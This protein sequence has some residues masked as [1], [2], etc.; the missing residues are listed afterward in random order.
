MLSL[1]R[2][3][4]AQTFVG[5]EAPLVRKLIPQFDSEEVD[6]QRVSHVWPCCLSCVVPVED[7]VED[8]WFTGENML[9]AIEDVRDLFDVFCGAAAFVIVV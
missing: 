1:E 3:V 6:W 4:D 2:I 5:M 7:G 9:Q 8:D